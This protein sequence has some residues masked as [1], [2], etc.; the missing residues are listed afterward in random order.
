MILGTYIGAGQAASMPLPYEGSGLITPLKFIV[1]RNVAGDA[2]IDK[3]A[4]ITFW[5]S[6]GKLGE[7][8]EG[9]GLEALR[10]GQ[11]FL[12]FVKRIAPDKITAG[13]AVDAS[14][15]GTQGMYLVGADERL[16]PI[17]DK[18]GQRARARR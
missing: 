9:N 13:P 2:P 1:E 5:V 4:E 16:N 18:A 6:G 15:L 10:E 7:R 17:S 12:L 3:R 14:L 11:R 8:V